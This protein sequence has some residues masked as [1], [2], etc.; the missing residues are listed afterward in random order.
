MEGRVS[1]TIHGLCLD[2]SG[3][4]RPGATFFAHGGKEGK[5]PL[6]STVAPSRLARLF[7]A[8]IGALPRNRLAASATGGASAVSASVQGSRVAETRASLSFLI[9]V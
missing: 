3:V 2:L 4:S 5:T 8:P 6:E 7:S 1:E 9:L